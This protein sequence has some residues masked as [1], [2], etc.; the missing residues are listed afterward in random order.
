VNLKQFVQERPL[1]HG[2]PNK[3]PRK[4]VFDERSEEFYAQLDSYMLGDVFRQTVRMASASAISG[5]RILVII[6]AHGQKY[7]GDI[8]LGLDRNT[9]K[10]HTV[11]RTEVEASLACG[12]SSQQ[13][14]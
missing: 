3:P 2:R 10:R 8:Y 14:P 6:V 9:S 4:V 1:K 13:L 7:T 11:S 12:W 5:E